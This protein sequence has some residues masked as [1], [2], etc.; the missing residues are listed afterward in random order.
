M[1]SYKSGLNLLH[2]DSDYAHK[3]LVNVKKAS[4]TPLT[5]ELC[6]GCTF[7]HRNIKQHCD[8]VLEQCVQGN[9]EAEQAEA[10]KREKEERK[11]RKEEEERKQA[12]EEAAAA[13]AAAAK[14]CRAL[15]LLF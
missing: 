2:C 14:V 10:R 7:P 9:I 1:A 6:N 5:P 13:A 11:R 15:L 3:C 4:F 12:E 8:S